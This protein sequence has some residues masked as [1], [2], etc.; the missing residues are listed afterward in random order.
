MERSDDPSSELARLRLRVNE[1]ERSSLAT[2]L[3]SIAPQIPDNLIL[4][5]REHRIRY[6]NWTVPD[7]TPEQVLGTPVTNYVPESYRISNAA[8]FDRVFASGHPERLL[9]E[10]AAEDGSISRWETRVVPISRNT[11]SVEQVLLVSSNITER[12]EAAV[13]LDRFFRLSVD[14]LCVATLSGYFKRVSPAF[15]ANLGWSADELERTPFLD[16][17][18]EDDR[19]STLETVE[20]LRS[21]GTVLDFENRYRMKSGGYRILQWRA[22]A[23]RHS[24]LIYAVA[25]DVTERR[26][27]ELELG[28]ARKMGTVGQLAGG[29]AHD[30]NNLILVS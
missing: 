30:F 14:M 11:G 1:L 10:Y 13:D 5:D 26:E 4:I 25:R 8:A 27:L 20:L 23:E 19:P 29:M 3:H 15:T 9:M 6:I 16:F 12:E 24:G 18:H 17:I 22:I 7:L 28:Q 2:F 21:G